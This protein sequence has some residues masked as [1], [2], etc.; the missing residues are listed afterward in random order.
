MRPRDKDLFGLKK[1]HGP[2]FFT[3]WPL[4]QSSRCRKCLL[5][6][7]KGLFNDRYESLVMLDASAKLRSG[8]LQYRLV[9][10]G[11]YEQC[12]HL[13]NSPAR[14]LL[15]SLEVNISVTSVLTKYLRASYLEFAS[16]VLAL[17][18]PSNCTES[19]IS[20]VTS[21][22]FIVNFNFPVHHIKLLTSQVGNEQYFTR[23]FAFPILCRT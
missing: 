13:T 9:D 10:F 18:I 15:L 3:T 8:L 14:Y 4:C 20:N 7:S 23:H 17:C 5:E 11:H 2:S 21:S 19:D 1:M 16:P 22:Q 12:L 6:H